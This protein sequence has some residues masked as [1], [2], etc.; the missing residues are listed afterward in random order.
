MNKIMMSVVLMAGL[1]SVAFSSSIWDYFH[2]L[3]I[4]HNAPN[5]A[6]I[7]DVKQM[8]Q[9]FFEYL[10]PIVEEQ[11]QKILQLRNKIK[12]QQINTYDMQQLAKKYRTT[13][14]HILASIDIIPTSLALSQAAIESNWGRSRFA[15]FNNYYGLWCFSKGCGV[16][17]NARE[18]GKTHEVATFRTIQQA[19]KKYIWTLNAHPAYQKLRNIRA[20]LRKQN[21]KISGLALALGLE[22]YSGIGYKYIEELQKMIKY[23]KLEEKELL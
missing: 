22:K 21:K 14:E 11:N 15:N 6:E 12:N 3:T 7:K 13:P 9:A 17:P 5:F 1:T 10:T 8:K 20:Q 4:V 2:K 18:S 19:T 23:N 16:V